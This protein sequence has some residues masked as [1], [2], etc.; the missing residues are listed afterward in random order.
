MALNVNV[1]KYDQIKLFGSRC[2]FRLS[3]IH[4]FILCKAYWMFALLEMHIFR[5]SLGAPR[6]SDP[7]ML[8]RAFRAWPA[9]HSI[10]LKCEAT[11]APP[12]KYTWLKDGNKMSTRRMDPYL[13]TSIWYLKL[14]DLV[15]NDSGT[16]TC[17][18]SN[19]YGSINHTYTLQVVGKFRKTKCSHARLLLKQ[20][21]QAKSRT[22]F[23]KV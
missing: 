2:R 4:L 19:P 18:V 21:P 3:V 5:F 14:R 13:N 11:G 6:F 23:Y 8:K 10:R 9:S 22:I 17:L 15:P 1:E 7:S 20:N 12:L 16:Y